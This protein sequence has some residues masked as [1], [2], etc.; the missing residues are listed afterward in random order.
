MDLVPSFLA[1]Q[2]H[3]M[4]VAVFHFVD[5]VHLDLLLGACQVQ[6]KMGSYVFEQI[7][8]QSCYLPTT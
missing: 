6:P 7:F 3:K 8:A 1:L 4:K 5:T 2:Q